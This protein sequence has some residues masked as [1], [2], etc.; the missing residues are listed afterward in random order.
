MNDRRMEILEATCTIV[1]Q[2]GVRDLS[3]QK[4][5][6]HM[7]LTFDE[8]DRHFP[9]ELELIH[10]AFDHADGR[11][12]AFV[13]DRIQ[14]ETTVQRLTHLLSLYIDDAPEIRE[15]WIFWMELE[16]GAIYDLD[17]REIVTDQTGMW[18]AMIAGLISAVQGE[19]IIDDR[20]DPNASALRLCLIQDSLAK[21]C[22]IGWVTVDEARVE[23]I[24]AL[25]HEL[26]LHATAER[27]V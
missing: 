25:D 12:T 11:A 22:V 8:V 19:G 26:G 16:T 4:V 3:L 1:A 24:R 6:D 15:D 21:Q 14:A 27:D 20:V 7:G 10:A 23:M 2:G 17:I 13:A 5:A 9:T 18:L